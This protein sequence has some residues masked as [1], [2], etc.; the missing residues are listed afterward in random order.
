[1]NCLNNKRGEAFMVKKK[2]DWHNQ[3]KYI[4]PT[5]EGKCPYCKNFVKSLEAHIHDAH[6]GEKMIKGK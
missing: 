2:R 6:K 4:K 5:T 3:P 1:M